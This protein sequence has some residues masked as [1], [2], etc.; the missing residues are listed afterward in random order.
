M[1]EGKER[2]AV[3]GLARKHQERQRA[4]EKSKQWEMSKAMGNEQSNGK[5][6][7]NNKEGETPGPVGSQTCSIFPGWLPVTG[8]MLPG[9]KEQKTGRAD[10]GDRDTRANISAQLGVWTL[11]FRC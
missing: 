6:Q 9:A 10:K 11:P 3:E 5:C 2:K 7:G 8:K 1:K 4:R